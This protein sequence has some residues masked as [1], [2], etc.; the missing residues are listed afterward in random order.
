[1]NRLR[2]SLENYL[3]HTPTALVVVDACRVVFVLVAFFGVLPVMKALAERP[4]FQAVLHRQIFY[5]E[6]YP[7]AAFFYGGMIRLGAALNALWIVSAIRNLIRLSSLRNHKTTQARAE[8]IEEKM[9]LPDYPF[10]PE[11]FAVVLG[12][13]QDRDGGRVPSK[14][15]P[16]LVPRWLSLPEKALYTGVFVTG[17][18][19]SGKTSAVA[20]P[21]LDQMIAMNRPVTVRRGGVERIERYR[22]SGLVMDEKGDFCAMTKRIMEAHGR[23]D[24]FIRLAPG[25]GTLWNVIYDPTIP[26]WAVGYSLG[27]ILRRFSKGQT[28]SDPFWEQA[29]KELTLDYLTLLDDARGYYTLSDYLEVLVSPVLQDDLHEQAMERHKANPAKV[30]EM[31]RRWRTIENRR[32]EMSDGLKSSLQACAKSGLTLFQFPE[33]RATFCPTKEEYF[34]AAVCPWPKRKPRNEAEEAAFNDEHEHGIVRPRENVFAGFDGILDTGKVIGLDM[35]KTAWFDAATFIQVALKSQWQNAVLRRDTRQA[36]GALMVPPRFGERVGYCPTFMIAD[37]CQDNVV[38]SDQEFLAKCRSKRASCIWLTQSHKSILGAMGADKK[39]D[40]DAFFQNNMTRIYL[41]QSDIESM[42]S[43]EEECGKKD[44]AKVSVALTEGG[45]QSH[46]SYVHGQVV[47]ENLAVSETKTSQIEEKPFFELEELRRMPNFVAVVLPSTGDE[48]LPAT[49]T[50]LRPSYVFRQ[51]PELR[52]ET[53]WHDW[54]DDL[55]KRTTL[56]NLPQEHT[57]KPWE[58]VD[59]EDGHDAL[60]GGFVGVRIKAD[61][62]KT[63]AMPSVALEELDAAAEPSE[64]PLEQDRGASF[65]PEATGRQV[66]QLEAAPTPAEPA[67]KPEPAGLNLAERQEAERQVQRAVQAKS[68]AAASTT[69][70]ASLSDDYEE[71]EEPPAPKPKL[72]L[73]LPW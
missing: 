39:A 43:I 31:E 34:G 4:D 47:N 22:F 48:T 5:S 20:E 15:S 50:Y 41:R 11:A 25:G 9:D 12:E 38:P 37:E 30:R 14:R 45:Q 19:G 73:D 35:P 2:R 72:D 58:A 29:P 70:S 52:M 42:K 68:A 64:H 28:G 33:I 23:A 32:E 1:M 61:A 49:L 13:L 10:K 7:T 18:I 6:S 54:P 24:D 59:L 62:P 21:M 51:R 36:D 65:I 56:G 16:E 55:K 66:D 57:W 53:S 3:E 46:L 40:A 17:G 44:V 27:Q 69:A 71:I 8:A 63:A 26:T 60:L 67:P